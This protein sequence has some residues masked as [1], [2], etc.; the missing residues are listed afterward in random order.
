MIDP[1]NDV[2]R[3]PPTLPGADVPPIATPKFDKNA[4]PAEREKAVRE[5]YPV[6]T[7]L[8]LPV[9]PKGATPLAWPTSR[10]WPS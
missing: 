1:K 10:R 7:P 2:F 3:V 5:A 6:L 8:A 4:T 9:P